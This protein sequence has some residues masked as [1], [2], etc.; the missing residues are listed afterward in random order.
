MKYSLIMVQIIVIMKKKKNIPMQK[1]MM[2]ES[3]MVNLLPLFPGL[4]LL[5]PGLFGL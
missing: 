4:H 3:N 2:G 1:S 5:Q